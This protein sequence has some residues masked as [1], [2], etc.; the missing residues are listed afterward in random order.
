MTPTRHQ[1]AYGGETV[2]YTLVRRPRRTLSITVHPDLRVT[3]VAPETAEDD[4]IHARVRKRARWVV[5]QRSRFLAW[6]PKPTKR[7]WKSGETHRYL[8]RQ[9]R[10]KVVQGGVTGVKL[11]GRYFEVKVKRPDDAEEVRGAMD[12]WI[13]EKAKERYA[14]TLTRLES[15]LRTYGLEP[16]RIRVRKMSKRWGSCIPDGVILLNPDL[17]KTPSVCVEYVVAHELCHLKHPHHG[18][19]FFQM[20]DAVMP[21]WEVRK[22]RL[23]HMEI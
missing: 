14:E 17:V 2:D 18:K 5:R 16:P 8:G 1:L 7:S 6:M 11:R 19:S 12:A 22:E 10:L 4:L 21:D 20:L 3:V 9:Y 15:T 13:R 23:E